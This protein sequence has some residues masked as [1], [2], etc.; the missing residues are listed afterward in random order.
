MKEVIRIQDEPKKDEKPIEF[1]HVLS[2]TKGWRKDNVNPND[3]DKTVYLGRCATDGDMFA[4][5]YSGGTIIIFKGHLNS[6]KY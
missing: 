3:Y 6:G 4:A 1:T 5:Y 2:D